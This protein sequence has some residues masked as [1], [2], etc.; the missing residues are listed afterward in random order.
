MAALAPMNPRNPTQPET[1]HASAHAGAKRSHA[2]HETLEGSGP[3][4]E[5]PTGRVG[6]EAALA[7][8]ETGTKSKE[9]LDAEA[10]L[11]EIGPCLQEG[12][13][14]VTISPKA[15]EGGYR[16]ALRF[17]AP[18]TFL[19]FEVG[20]QAGATPRIEV[21]RGPAYYGLMTGLLNYYYV[22]LVP[23]IPESMSH[24]L[25]PSL[26]GDRLSLEG[27]PPSVTAARRF[28]SSVYFHLEENYALVIEVPTPGQDPLSLKDAQQASTGIKDAICK[29]VQRMQWLALSPEE[30]EK[31]KVDN[32]TPGSEPDELPFQLTEVLLGTPVA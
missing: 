17:T 12:V 28:L 11:E 15:G 30:K 21:I 32:Y 20:M 29:A 18:K 13:E 1:T 19:P 7:Q 3:G 25:M 16:V 23:K 8:I 27:M 22:Q 6:Y 4:I 31:K 2:L 10:L 5:D 26:Q 14:I 9:L 24:N